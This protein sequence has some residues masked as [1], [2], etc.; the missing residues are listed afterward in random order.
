MN[1]ALAA[2]ARALAADVSCSVEASE[3]PDAQLPAG[4]AD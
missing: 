3:N 4:V 1:T 2:R